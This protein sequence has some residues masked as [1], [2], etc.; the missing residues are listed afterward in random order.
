MT[1]DV[2]VD[3][4]STALEGKHIALGVSGGIAAT[5]TIRICRELRRHGG[6]I[7]VLM[8][9]AACKVITP[10]AVEWA[11]QGIVISEWN[12]AMTQLDDFDAVLITPASRNF[13]SRYVNGM[14][15]HPLLMTCSAARSKSTPIV[16][17]PSMHQDLFDD[18]VTQD[19]LERLVDESIIIG[20]HEEGRYKQPNPIQ[21]VAELCHVI[22]KKSINYH[23]A[24][25]MGANRAPI[26]SVRAIQNASS[27]KTGWYIA[28]YLYRHG[29]NV[30]VIA[31]KTSANP[32]FDLPHI[33]RAGSPDEMLDVCIDVAKSKP[34]GWIHAAAV[35]DYYTEALD[36]KKKSGG[37]AWELSL[38]QGPKHIEVLK[39]YVGEAR[40]IGFKLETGVSVDE[41]H[42]RALQQIERYGVDATVANIM[43]EMHQPSS[44]RAY[45]V[46]NDSIMELS[47]MDAVCESIIGVLTT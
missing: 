7:T 22:N 23:V 43:E 9:P 38:K 24:I 36:G 21:I 5:E 47:D 17:V 18:P 10:L 11:S 44:P 39:E 35:L 8:T 33:I 3:C 32:S 37:D 20:P 19:L 45:F 29:F 30:T 28:E 27:G 46:T 12:S 34:D 42:D 13:I 4:H 6:Q 2:D 1:G 31:G 26:D 15:D 25:T 16:I 40:R 41:L 14:M